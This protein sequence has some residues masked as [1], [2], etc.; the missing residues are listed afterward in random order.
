MKN[1]SSIWTRIK[2]LT[3]KVSYVLIFILN[4]NIEL[5][6]LAAIFEG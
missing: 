6:L 3:F 1:A 5:D 2:I 4:E